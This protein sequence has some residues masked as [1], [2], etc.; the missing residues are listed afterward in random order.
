MNDNTVLEFYFIDIIRDIKDDKI[1]KEL[2][3]EI[4]KID[5]FYNIHLKDI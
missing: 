1:I 2:L 4:P 3:K 5:L